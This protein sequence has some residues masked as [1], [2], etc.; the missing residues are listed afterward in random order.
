MPSNCFPLR[1]TILDLRTLRDLGEVPAKV[2]TDQ[3]GAC[4]DS[5]HCRSCGWLLSLLCDC[6]SRGVSP[7]SIA[8]TRPWLKMALLIIPDANSCC[9][10]GCA[11]LARTAAMCV[12]ATAFPPR[13]VQRGVPEQFRLSLRAQNLRSRKLYIEATSVVEAMLSKAQS[14]W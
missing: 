9:G 8:R 14:K 2:G 5:A 1:V 13:P 11:Q 10:S 3:C 12:V 4:R 6:T 7:L